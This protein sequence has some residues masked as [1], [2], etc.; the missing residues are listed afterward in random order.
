MELDDYLLRLEKNLLFGSARWVADFTE[1]FRRYSLGGVTFDMV[2]T[3]KMR[4]KGFLLSRVVSYLLMPN[5][6]SACLVYAGELDARRL[7]ELYRIALD[8][9]EREELRWVWL[10]LPQK[11]P[12]PRKLRSL[13]TGKENSDKLGVALVDLSSQEVFTDESRLGRAMARHVRCFR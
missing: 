10:V 2:I 5:Y 7:K 1:S 9:A 4:A 8:Y 3:G 6:Y 12:L 13:V 11:E